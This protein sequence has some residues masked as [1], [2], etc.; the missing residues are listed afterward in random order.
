MCLYQVATG[1]HI[2]T[3]LGHVSDIQAVAFSPNN[4]LLASASFDGSIL[5]WDLT[6]YL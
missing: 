4:E 5:L 2:V 1:K 3:F 6:P